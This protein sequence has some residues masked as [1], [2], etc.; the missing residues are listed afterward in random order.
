MDEISITKLI[1]KIF[2][3]K[4]K[5]NFLKFIPELVGLDSTNGLAVPDLMHL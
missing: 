2:I 1:Y 5:E 3:F 4:K